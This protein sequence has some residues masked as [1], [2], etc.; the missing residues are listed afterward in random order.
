MIIRGNSQTA[1]EVLGEVE[2]ELFDQSWTKVQR[3]I[4]GTMLHRFLLGSMD[5]SNG[6]KYKGQLLDFE[7]HGWGEL[8]IPGDQNSYRGLFEKGVKHGFGQKMCGDQLCF[9]DFEKGK[10]RSPVKKGK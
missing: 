5:Y 10:E 6:E 3:K 4:R 7:P 1:V 2:V 8:T 9:F